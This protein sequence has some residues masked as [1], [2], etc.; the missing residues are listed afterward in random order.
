MVV[1]S[2]SHLSSPYMLNKQKSFQDK[3]PDVKDSLLKQT[4][5]VRK[6]KN[7]QGAETTSAEEG[8]VEER[9]HA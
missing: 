8:M 3:G 6:R 7:V 5:D 1:R 9:W 4:C 2:W